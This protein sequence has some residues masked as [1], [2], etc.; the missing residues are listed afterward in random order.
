M[1]TTPSVGQVIRYSYLW[2]EEHLA[3]REEGLKDR[4]CVIVVAVEVLDRDGLFVTVLPVTHAPPSDPTIAVEIPH[5][6]KRRLG[7]DEM[8][9][10]IILSESNQFLWPGPDIR[11][12]DGKKG[13]PVYGVLPYKLITRVRSAF[14]SFIRAKRSAIIPRTE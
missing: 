4:P 3:G 7:L 13:S 6:T 2:R 10:W 8:Q 9:S 1:S 14:T 11:P 5:L 12:I